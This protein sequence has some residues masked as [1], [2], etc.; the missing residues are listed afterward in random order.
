MPVKEMSPALRLVAFLKT[1]DLFAELPEQEL[2]DLSAQL[3]ELCYQKGDVICRKSSLAHTI[4]F[5]ETG[6]VSEFAVDKNDF[7]CITKTRRRCDYFGELGALLDECYATTVV[8]DAPCMVASLPQRVFCGI[9]WR[10]PCCVKVLLRT[11]LVRLQRSAEKHISFTLFNAEGR[12]AYTML[13]LQDSGAGGRFVR[14]TQEELAQSCGIARQTASR[15]LNDWKQLGIIEIHRGK[16]WVAS[17]ALL[18][19]VLL[20]SANSR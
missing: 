19:E 11:C 6:T 5:I 15:I 8:A 18:A 14:I 17:P 4:Y 7:S 10:N 2:A 20:N 9:V 1:V 13:L 16:L 12:L 3:A